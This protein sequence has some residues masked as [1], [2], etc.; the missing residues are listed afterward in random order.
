MASQWKRTITVPENQRD[1][2]SA[3]CDLMIKL[4]N[5][6]VN[7]ESAQ[8]VRL[9]QVADIE[10]V[11]GAS[12]I[13]RLDQSREVLISADVSGR[14]MDDITADLGAVIAEQQPPTGYRIKFGGNADD[15]GTAA[16]SLIKVLIMA[17][18]FIYVVRASQF[19]SF[20]QPLAIM[21]ALPLSPVG[22]L[23]GL[24]LTGSTINMFSMTGFIML[25]GLVTKN[26]ILLVDFANREPRTS[27]GTFDCRGRSKCRR[28]TFSP[29]RHDDAGDDL[30]DGSSRACNLWCRCPEGSHGTCGDRRAFE[31]DDIHPDYCPGHHFLHR[32]LDTEIKRAPLA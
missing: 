9:N 8:M 24:L 13:R 28:G 18:I 19:G 2:V 15:V 6:A 1:S 20:L 23:I 10:L 3:I 4:P 25:M 26:G 31:L 22:M 5:T 12:E 32:Q 27:T 11:P 29:N 30:R 21:A 17:V 14:A 16:A 7:G